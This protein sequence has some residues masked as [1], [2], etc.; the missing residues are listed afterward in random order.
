[1]EE[2][3]VPWLTVETKNLMKERDDLKAV[4]MKLA[5]EGHET[6]EA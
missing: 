1:M 2:K 6:K 4:A 3:F 5:R